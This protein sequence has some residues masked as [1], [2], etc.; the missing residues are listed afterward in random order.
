MPT[1]GSIGTF[2]P[3]FSP[4]LPAGSI[5]TTLATSIA[6]FNAQLTPGTP[7]VGLSTGN[8][9]VNNGGLTINQSSPD[10]VF[11]FNKSKYSNFTRAIQ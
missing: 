6:V 2:N 10:G 1:S 4:Q 11:N 9:F 7:A 8:L 3:I 5:T